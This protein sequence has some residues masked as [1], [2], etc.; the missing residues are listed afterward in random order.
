M[1]KFYLLFII[2]FLAAFSLLAQDDYKKGDA[3]FKNGQYEQALNFFQSALSTYT[4][5]KNQ[6][7]MADANNSMGLV[8]QV[9]NQHDKAV[10]N[11]QTAASLY[12]VTKNKSGAASA[13]ANWGISA[14]RVKEAK[15]KKVGQSWDDSSIGEILA[16]HLKAKQLHDESKDKAGAGDD[17]NNIATM[18][19]EAEIYDHAADYLNQALKIHQELGAKGGIATD[20]ANLGRLYYKTGND[21]DALKFYEKSSGMFDE[22]G[23][24][25]NAW[26]AYSFCAVLYE[27]SA[28]QNDILNQTDLAA[29]DEGNWTL[30][31]N[32]KLLPKEGSPVKL[33][34]QAL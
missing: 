33:I 22:L 6:A 24:R 14:F 5:S 25:E 10:G 4:S 29:K 12:V 27:T 13:F 20:L 7:G 31:V 1:K 30:E 16:F 26:K 28:R 34:I 9:L 17:L 11:F 21:K 2:L 19:F 18:Y 15:L 32:K 8:L 23:D 3:A